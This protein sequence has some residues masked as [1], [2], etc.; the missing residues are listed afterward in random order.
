MQFAV[1]PI[2][3]G[4]S[5]RL[6]IAYPNTVADPLSLGDGELVAQFRASIDAAG[7]PLFTARKSEGSITLA[8]GATETLL[9]LT[10]P[11]TATAGMTPDRDITFDIV[12]IDGA[13]RDVIPGRWYWPVRKTVTRDV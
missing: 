3:P 7:D 12:R 6:D 4:Y 11:A 8:R 1:E 2:A 10:L 13:V 9:T 5:A